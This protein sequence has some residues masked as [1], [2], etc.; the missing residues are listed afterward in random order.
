MSNQAEIRFEKSMQDPAKRLRIL[1][2]MQIKMALSDKDRAMAEKAKDSDITYKPSAPNPQS[3]QDSA[4]R[5]ESELMRTMRTIHN[6]VGSSS[7]PSDK[8]IR[9]DLRNLGFLD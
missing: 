7:I 3:P 2:I 6:A 8:M 4:N 5:K 1:A 9:T